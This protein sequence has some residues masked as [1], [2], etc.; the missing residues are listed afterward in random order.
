MIPG[1]ANSS[2]FANGYGESIRLQADKSG[3][4]V[5]G[6]SKLSVVNWI[7]CQVCSISDGGDGE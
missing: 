3:L 5:V 2:S 7:A 4:L 6:P 1:Q